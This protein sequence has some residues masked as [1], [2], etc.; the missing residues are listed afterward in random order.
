M[1]GFSHQQQQAG[2]EREA[3]PMA[4]EE[5][6]GNAD[7]LYPLPPKSVY[8]PFIDL[9]EDNKEES[10]FQPPRVDWIQEDG[11]W[12]VF[13][14]TWPVRSF[15]HLCAPKTQSNRGHRSKRHFLR[16]RRWASPR[17]MTQ[18]QVR[19]PAPVF[20]RAN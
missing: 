7:S 2:E 8:A 17:S 13:G 15:R 12:Q 10:R 9:T 19:H 6:L 20:I 3:S 5:M 1:N 18:T 14:Q 16:L 4:A 11:N